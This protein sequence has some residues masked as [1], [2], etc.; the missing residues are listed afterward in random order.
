MKI[1]QASLLRA[2]LN[3]YEQIP[4]DERQG[5][6]EEQ[7]DGKGSQRSKENTLALDMLL[8]D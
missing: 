8:I 1:Y 5:W 3:F 2:L 4:V 6:I 7:L